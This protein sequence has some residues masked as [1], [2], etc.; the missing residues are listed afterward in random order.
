MILD[1]EHHTTAR[2]D[3]T[4]NKWDIKAVAHYRWNN[5]KNQPV[6]PWYTELT[7][8]LNW[9]IEYDHVHNRR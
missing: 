9:I 1:K 5:S 6:S 2:W 3:S 4:N 8:A 7:E